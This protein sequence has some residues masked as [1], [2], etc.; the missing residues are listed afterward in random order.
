MK[1]GKKPPGGYKNAPEHS[2]FKKGQSGNP[3]GRPKDAKGIKTLFAKEL[4]ESITIQQDGK[5]K[6]IRRSEALAK[7]W[8]MTLCEDAIGLAN[9]F[10]ATPKQSNTI[11]ASVPRDR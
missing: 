3:K 9:S 6:R 11:N 7:G 10:F 1:S 5:T 8:S 2:K 4:Q